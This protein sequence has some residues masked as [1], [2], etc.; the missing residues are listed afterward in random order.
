MKHST[1][2][3]FQQYKD[4]VFTFLVIDQLLNQ[5]LENF[6]KI[7]A[8]EEYEKFSGL[9][10]GAKIKW[11]R[12]KKLLGEFPTL[13]KFNDFRIVIVHRDV[14]DA[15]HNFATYHDN[16]LVAIPEI[17][18]RI[19]YVRQAWKLGQDLYGLVQMCSA[20]YY[21][22]KMNEPYLKTRNPAIYL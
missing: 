11:L 6:V 21:Y 10:L 16:E 4:S 12:K 18:K 5:E 7:I 14:L 9:A 15:W 19:K 3:L 2:K 20:D 8:T 13:E 17:Q 22:I 1:Q